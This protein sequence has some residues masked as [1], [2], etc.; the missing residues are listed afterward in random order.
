MKKFPPLG[1]WFD[2]RL[3]VSNTHGYT[4]H[5]LRL[6]DGLSDADIE[7]LS[8]ELALLIARFRLTEQEYS[9]WLKYW[10]NTK[11]IPSDLKKRFQYGFWRSFVSSKQSDLP[12]GNVCPDKTALQGHIGEIIMYLIQSQFSDHQIMT[13]PQKP[14]EY[15]KDSGID[16]LELCG[17]VSKP[18]TLHYV[19]WESKAI[20][21]PLLGKYPGK[22]YDQHLYMTPKSFKEMV[23]QLVDKCED[24][25][26]LSRFVSKMVKDFFSARPTRKK[27]FGGCVSYSGQ[28]FAPASAF[29][30]FS[31]RFKSDLAS[32]PRCKQVRL[33]AVGKLSGITD[34]VWNKV[35][36]KLRP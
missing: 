23:D 7:S 2:V 14:K 15:S 24:D 34:E 11:P 35:W 36:N 13:V 19:V 29:S 30:G 31:I 6:K 28:K 33:C 12:N 21:S 9:D 16:C 4:R 5:D 3:N 22:I 20:T 26:D 27:C 32:D 18:R 10:K 25:P 1:R 8:D 17:M